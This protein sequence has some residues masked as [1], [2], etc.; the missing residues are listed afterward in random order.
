VDG[1]KFRLIGVG[2]TDLADAQ[3]HSVLVMK[4]RARVAGRS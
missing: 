4:S 1:R 3:G 2:C